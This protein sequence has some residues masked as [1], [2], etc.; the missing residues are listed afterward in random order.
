MF[1]SG[2]YKLSYEVVC[3][4]IE[5]GFTARAVKPLRGI[6]IVLPADQPRKAKPDGQPI[7]ASKAYMNSVSAWRHCL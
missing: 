7:R 6:L 1:G 2:E 4:L 3:G 5:V